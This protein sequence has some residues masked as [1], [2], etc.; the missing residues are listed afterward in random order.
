MT[1]PAKSPHAGRVTA[2][3]TEAA[4]EAIEERPVEAAPRRHNPLAYQGGRPDIVRHLRGPRRVLDVGCNGGAV[5][6]QIRERDP[7]ARVWGIEWN[8]DAL[9]AAEPVLEAGFRVDLE[10]REALRAALRGLTFDAVIAGDVL[11]HLSDPWG[12][13]EDLFRHVAAGG[14][15]LISLPNVGRWE[16]IAHL[17]RQRWPVEDRGVFDRTHRRF[18]MKN[19]LPGLAP[20]GGRLRILARNYRIR[21]RGRGRADR[22]LLPVLRRIP[23]LRELFVFQYILEVRREA[24]AGGPAC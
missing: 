7:N 23:R 22:F 8:V 4:C 15:V 20:A 10:D 18:F 6:R 2:D 1:L 19:D 3:S 5:A 14:V 13:L 16:L 17:A 11:E 12:V 24:D 9:A 21:E